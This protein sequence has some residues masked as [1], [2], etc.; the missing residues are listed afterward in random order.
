MYKNI[1]LRHS[2]L[3][4]SLSL[5]LIQIFIGCERLE[6]DKLLSSLPLSLFD[7]AR[8]RVAFSVCVEDR[9]KALPEAR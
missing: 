3:V 6:K 2:R 1:A 4:G 8:E 7:R 5:S 9:Q